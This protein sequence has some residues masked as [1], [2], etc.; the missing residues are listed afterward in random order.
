MSRQIR[1]CSSFTPNT[2]YHKVGFPN[3]CLPCIKPKFTLFFKT[4]FWENSTALHLITISMAMQNFRNKKFSN[5][6]W[7]SIPPVLTHLA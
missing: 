6:G 3:K 5:K 2:D 7:Q 1:L 4:F